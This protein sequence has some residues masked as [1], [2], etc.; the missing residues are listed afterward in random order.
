MAYTKMPRRDKGRN[1]A[2]GRR[3]HRSLSPMTEM[4]SSQTRGNAALFRTTC[5]DSESSEINSIGWL[6][7]EDSNLRLPES[8]SGALPLGYAPI[9]ARAAREPHLIRNNDRSGQADIS[10][11]ARGPVAIANHVVGGCGRCQPKFCR[12]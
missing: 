6:G 2:Q 8:K 11:P 7:R 4:A 3:A 9:D 10:K 12:L 5:R 1:S